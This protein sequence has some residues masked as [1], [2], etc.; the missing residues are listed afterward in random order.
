MDD[1]LVNQQVS[2]KS[3]TKSE[4]CAENLPRNKFRPITTE[5]EYFDNWVGKLDML[6][7]KQSEIGMIG[8][9]F[10]VGIM[11]SMCWAPKFSDKYGRYGLAIA[12][13]TVQFLALIGLYL[14]H[15]IHLTS[16][17][18]IFLGMSHPGKNII[19]FN[20]LLEMVPSKYK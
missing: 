15:D 7:K 2:W 18:M 3:C 20:Y 8:A 13:Y 9:S 19:F 4:I 17:F 6:C 16:I 12:T 5:A 10:F 1:H 14:S 11:I